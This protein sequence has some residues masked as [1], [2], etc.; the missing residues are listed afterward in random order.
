MLDKKL[1]WIKHFHH[2]KS[3]TKKGLSL[4]KMISKQKS[5]S[6]MNISFLIYLWIMDVYYMTRHPIRI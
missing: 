6:D 1:L 5:G 4:L 2:W 3:K